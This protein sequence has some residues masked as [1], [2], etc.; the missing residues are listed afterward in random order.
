MLSL[1]MLTLRSSRKKCSISEAHCLGGSNMSSVDRETYEANSRVL[2]S[3]QHN[4][5]TISV[6]DLN[7]ISQGKTPTHTV[8]EDSSDAYRITTFNGQK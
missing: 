2:Q 1:L 7:T 3:N 8:T 6:S 5:V 4:V